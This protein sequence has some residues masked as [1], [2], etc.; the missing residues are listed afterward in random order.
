MGL[1]LLAHRRPAPG[2]QIG[3][4]HV[5]TTFVGSGSLESCGKVGP[6]G[7]VC[8][9]ATRGTPSGC[10]PRDGQNRRSERT[11]LL[12]YLPFATLQHTNTHTRARTGVCVLY[13]QAYIPICS[14]RMCWEWLQC[15]KQGF[16]DLRT[17][18]DLRKRSNT[19]ATTL[20]AN[21]PRRLQLQPLQPRSDPKRALEGLARTPDPGCPSTLVGS[22][23][24][25]PGHP[26]A[27][28]RGV[29]SG[30]RRPVEGV[31]EAVSGPNRGR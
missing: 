9:I 17:P 16:F 7:R 10:K 22:P 6:G 8:N 29:P 20:V 24:A 2:A 14:L 4:I 27:A 13:P 31:P 28:C 1:P 25:V 18:S 5:A 3:Q 30:S 23:E 26:S 12:T 21:A 15:C 19:F 11:C